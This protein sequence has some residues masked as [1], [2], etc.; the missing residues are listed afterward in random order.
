MGEEIVGR[1]RELEALERFLS[2]APHGACGLV[3][4]GEPGIGKS[5]VWQ[6]ALPLAEQR[7][8]RVAT[9]RPA[10][11]EATL[12]YAALGD[13]LADVADE[14]AVALPDPQR[15]ALDI[16]L[17]RAEG[18]GRGADRRAVS[19]A[20]LGALK[21]LAA[22]RPLVLA[23]DDV[24]WIDGASA[25][26]LSFA[27]RRLT[28]ERV[29]V[30]A[31]LRDAGGLHDPIAIEGC[32]GPRAERV[33]VD[34]LGVDSIAKI[35]RM[36]TGAEL[37]RPTLVRVHEAAL[38][39]PLFALEIVRA[40][41]RDG[42]DLLP[43]EPLP[44]PDDLEG[45][46]HA[47]LRRLPARTRNALLLAAATTRPTVH[48][49]RAATPNV[50]VDVL[51]PA[52]D[53][54][55]VRVR[56]DEVSFT[57][58]LLASTVYR[59]ASSARRRDAHGR[60][61]DAVDDPEE[62]A[63]HLALAA[64]EP[65]ADVADALEDAAHGASGRGAPAAAAEL[66]ELARRMTPRDDV[67]AS[68]RRAM[69]AAEYR[70][71]S[72]DAV[73][74]LALA[75][76]IL[77]ATPP[78]P[79]RAEI[80]YL[81]SVFSWNDVTRLRPVLDAVVADLEGPSALLAA[82]IADLGWVEILGGD[83]RAASAKAREAIELAGGLDDPGPLSLGL[84]TAAYAEYMLGRD[85]WSLLDRALDLQLDPEGPGAVSY[86][87][88]S[89]RNTLGALLMWSGDLD[90]A[91]SELELH[92]EHLV[93]RGQYLP[94]WEGF[95]YLSELETR[96]G[97]F[98]KALEHAEELLETMVEGG[99]EQAR[100]TGL[101]V[102]ALA[103]AHLGLADRSRA[104]AIEGLSLAERHGDVF[105]VITNRSVL[106]FLELS[107]SHH[108]RAER[109]LAPLP[110][111]LSTRGIVEPGIYPFP[112]DLVEALVGMGD[113]DRA[114]SVLAP[115]EHHASEHA[116]APALAASAR[117]RGLMAAAEGDFDRA[118]AS[119]TSS[120]ELH[121][122]MSQPF[123][124]A[125]SQ[126]ALGD[127]RRRAKQKRPARDALETAVRMFDDLGASLWAAKA[128]RSLARISGRSAPHELTATERQI[129][130]LVVTGLTNREVAD[131]LFV[132][133]RTVESNLSRV[134][135]KLGIASRRELRAEMLE[136]EGSR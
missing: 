86:S 53:A 8:Y 81:I 134:Y 130:G 84:V 51:G 92:A 110:E 79:G 44:A 11:S 122:G 32:L 90:R 23:V 56:A 54:D 117:C 71:V 131:S 85:V 60:L 89:A 48:V 35:V 111:L 24:Q 49:L 33:V 17:L 104:D 12:T 39:N 98:S 6:A 68:R 2:S 96:A 115:Y 80:G 133:V 34:A 76:E 63:R 31:T 50:E 64:A 66:A 119:I 108:E 106:G 70:F 4:A 29:G 28:T 123:E 87:L 13:L 67:E 101:W 124:L 25:S 100:E 47:R 99:Y 126:L 55:I 40:L 45:L 9:S 69:K 65:S 57:H 10:G 21:Q 30:L 105:H 103:L 129:A 94:L 58:P 46:L 93:E 19:T 97:N 114:G 41:R 128:R 121:A 118:T 36:W 88:V 42:P 73:A 82:A 62:R 72:G 75:E 102:R 22:E 136:P 127:V 61:A 5:T 59:R 135:S 18:S 37:S 43:G 14:L 20:T 27:L 15:R 95:I 78:G 132:S 74:A 1:E 107:F 38:G 116:R 77:E 125:R 16:A 7:G 112:P 113:L 91:R 109:W 52:E 3:L 26:A 83:L 120:I